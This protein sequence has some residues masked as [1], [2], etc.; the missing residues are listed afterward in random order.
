M[1]EIDF[2]QEEMIALRQHSTSLISG[3]T[4]RLFFYCVGLIVVGRKEDPSDEWPFIN[5]DKINI[6]WPLAYDRKK[7]QITQ[8]LMKCMKLGATRGD[9]C[10]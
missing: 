5:G 3:S 9:D 4:W 6:V 7:K 1:L 2:A 8:L 10:C